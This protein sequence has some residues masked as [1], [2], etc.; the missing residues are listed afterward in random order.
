MKVQLNHGS[1]RTAQADAKTIEIEAVIK[2]M[3]R[4]KSIGDQS[5]NCSNGQ[6]E[7]LEGGSSSSSCASEKPTKM[8]KKHLRDQSEEEYK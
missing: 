8:R 7:I 2:C 3:Q 6:E 5:D 4:L 1:K